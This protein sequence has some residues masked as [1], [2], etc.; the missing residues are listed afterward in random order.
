MRNI[1]TN[2]LE[3]LQSSFNLAPKTI[4]ILTDLVRRMLKKA[5]QIVPNLDK[6]PVNNEVQRILSENELAQLFDRVK[7]NPRLRTF[8]TMLYYTAQR[9]E[10]I[11]RLQKKHIINDT[12]HIKEI[13]G[14]KARD[15]PISKKLKPIIKEWV[16]E[17]QPDEYLFHPEN[18]KYKAL[19]YNQLNRESQQLF[20]PFNKGLDFKEDRLHWASLY[21]LRHTAATVMLKSA[22]NQRVVQAALNHSSSQMTE[23]YAKVINE[24]LQEGFDGL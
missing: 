2:D 10:S 9:P 6:L 18:N 20:E 15:I 24:S 17:L 5:N 22:G 16:K 3:K 13:K 8:V 11:L 1:T 21:S 23:R 19:S 14:Q 12:I 4:N 7:G